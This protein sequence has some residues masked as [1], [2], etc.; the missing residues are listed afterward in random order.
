[1]TD[2]RHVFGAGIALSLIL[3]SFL[4]ADETSRDTKSKLDGVWIAEKVISSGH[5]VP[6][7]KFPFELHFGNGKLIFRFIGSVKGKDRIHDIVV[8]NNQTPATI[9]M[10]REIPG[11]P[12]DTRLPRVRL[13]WTH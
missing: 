7:A 5:V 2:R 12:H 3:S 8:D 6:A 9:D 10:T 11:P 4:G 1:M 13:A